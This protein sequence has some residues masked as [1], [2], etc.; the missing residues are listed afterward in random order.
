[1]IVELAAVSVVNRRSEPGYLK[2]NI[3]KCCLTALPANGAMESR[4]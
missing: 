1:M 3:I 2:E 4:Y